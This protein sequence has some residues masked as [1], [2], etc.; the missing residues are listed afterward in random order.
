MA[1]RRA[2]SSS[3]PE[4]NRVRQICPFAPATLQDRRLYIRGRAVDFPCSVNWYKKGRDVLLYP[5]QLIAPIFCPSQW[6]E[7]NKD[8]ADA[9]DLWGGKPARVTDG[10]GGRWEVTRRKVRSE[11]GGGGGCLLHVGGLS[12][13]EVAGATVSIV[14]WQ[15]D[16]GTVQIE[17]AAAR[18]AGGEAADRTTTPAQTQTKQSK[19]D[20]YSNSSTLW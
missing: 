12:L 11:M 4:G 14:V 17:V 6:F 8:R 19:T 18:T 15:V 2:R 9:Q 7:M 5:R 13:V 3:L 10:W 20:A 1:E 16:G